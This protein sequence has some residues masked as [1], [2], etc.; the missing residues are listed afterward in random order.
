MYESRQTIKLI[1]YNLN[2]GC[3][4]EL[5]DCRVSQQEFI[6]KTNADVIALQ[7]TTERFA[8]D[9][10]IDLGF[11][12]NYA[13][14]DNGF[15]NAILSRFP[16][17]NHFSATIS[18]SWHPEQRSLL[19]VHVT[20]PTYLVHLAVAVTHLENSKESMR[21][22]QITKA[23]SLLREH[24]GQDG[25]ILCGDFNAIRFADYSTEMWSKFL[26]FVEEREWDP[27]E[28]QVCTYMRECGY[29]DTF[30]EVGQGE[31]W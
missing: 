20:I 10:A 7:L 24:A 5:E 3:N 21:T 2:R 27:R 9:L 12:M 23:V 4:S 26:K 11:T 13:E 18:E 1:T 8:T 25:H 15:G 14:A 16:V 19:L 6:S 31:P 17:T 22:S 29:L 28:E 30:L